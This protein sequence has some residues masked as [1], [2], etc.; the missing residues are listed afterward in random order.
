M[1][2]KYIDWRADPFTDFTFQIGGKEIRVNRTIVSRQSEVL[3]TMFLA[4]K[5]EKKTGSVVIE[6]TDFDVMLALFNYIYEQT[7]GHE[8][9][10][11]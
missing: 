7:F 11:S 6:D 9:P 10:D 8:M 1:A 4:D 2:N 3:K 5:K